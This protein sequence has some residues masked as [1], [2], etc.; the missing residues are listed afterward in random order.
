MISC[1]A[2]RFSQPNL[3]LF[4]AFSYDYR[5]LSWFWSTPREGRH[6]ILRGNDR[7]WRM[8]GNIAFHG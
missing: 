8:G 1:A 6:R 7:L 4:S 2:I 3:G 5:S